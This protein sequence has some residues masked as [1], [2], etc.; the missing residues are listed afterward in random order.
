MHYLYAARTARGSRARIRASRAGV[1]QP[2]E[3]LLPKRSVAISSDRGDSKPL[4]CWIALTN[5]SE[6]VIV[7]K[8]G[9]NS[10]TVDIHSELHVAM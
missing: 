6:V 8:N 7:D 1:A 9:R 10:A 3:R 4:C 5:P 2:A